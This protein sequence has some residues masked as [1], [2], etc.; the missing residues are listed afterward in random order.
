MFHSSQRICVV[1]SLKFVWRSSHQCEWAECGIVSE[2]P[3][4]EALRFLPFEQVFHLATA[5]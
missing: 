4:S 1:G 5:Q 3:S 2:A